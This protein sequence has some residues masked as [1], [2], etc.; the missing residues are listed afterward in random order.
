MEGERAHHAI[1]I[2]VIEMIFVAF[3][4]GNFLCA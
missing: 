1:I 2:E 4:D 3:K